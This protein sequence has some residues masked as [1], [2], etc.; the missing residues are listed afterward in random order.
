MTENQQSEPK[1]EHST[2]V[3]QVRISYP[4]PPK[5]LIF[6]GFFIYIGKKLLKSYYEVTPKEEHSKELWQICHD[7]FFLNYL[8]PALFKK[9]LKD[10]FDVVSLA[11][12]NMYEID[13]T[14]SGVLFC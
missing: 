1:E 8:L 2:L 6:Q 7:W 5:A 10:F 9:I 11:C 14:P 12:T 3:L 4:A 13:S